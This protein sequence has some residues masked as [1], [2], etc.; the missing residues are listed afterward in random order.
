LK[1]IEYATKIALITAAR[2]AG[3][4]GKNQKEE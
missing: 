1:N 4:A 2:A 3:G